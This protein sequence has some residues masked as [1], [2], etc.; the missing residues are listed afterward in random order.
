M[1]A[2][3]PTLLPSM[4]TSAGAATYV[5]FS[6]RSG[7]SDTAVSVLRGLAGRK[8]PCGVRVAGPA[9]LAG[10]GVG[11]APAGGGDVRQ[12]GGA[13]AGDR[14]LGREGGAAD[15]RRRG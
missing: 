10:A 1:P 14:G 3:R 2:T 7:S 5:S 4:F 8:R 6:R 13:V 15:D 12:R 9:H 11:D